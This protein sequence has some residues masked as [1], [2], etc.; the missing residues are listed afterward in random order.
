MSLEQKKSST[1]HSGLDDRDVHFQITTTGWMM[2]NANVSHLGIGATIVTYDGSPIYP[3]KSSL[4]DLIDA[5][6]VTSFSLSPRYLQ[7]LLQDGLKPRETHKLTSLKTIFS[8][9]SP[10]KPELY[11]FFRRDIKDVF[12]HNGSGGTD[13]CAGFIGAI[14]IL[15]VYQGV[16]Q[17]PMLGVA[18]E[19]FDEN[20]NPY[21]NGEEGDLVLTRPLPNMPIGFLG[22]DVSDT[23]LRE[24]YFTHFPKKTAWY[25]ADYSES[26]SLWHSRTY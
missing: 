9:G 12:I 3:T 26:K 6:G 14:P 15:P 2:W 7:L 13:V 22:D 23:K 8:A 11:E 25:Q 18:A 1:L 24:T 5:Y 20:G 4:F 16:I 17:G 10:L 21:T 19:C